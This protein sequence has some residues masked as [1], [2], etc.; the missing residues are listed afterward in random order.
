MSSRLRLSNLIGQLADDEV[1]VLCQI[2]ERLAMGRTLYGKL[3]IATD[4]RDF[5]G[6]EAREEAFDLAVYLAIALVKAG[7]GK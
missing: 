5:G 1:A 6:K 7:R 4:K 2:A 3:D